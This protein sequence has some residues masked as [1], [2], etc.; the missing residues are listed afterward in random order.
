MLRD[1][2]LSWI[3]LK[4]LMRTYPKITLGH[5]NEKSFHS[6][7]KKQYSK[8]LLYCLNFLFSPEVMVEP[9]TK[10]I[11]IIFTSSKKKE[12]ASEDRKFENHWRN[13]WKNRRKYLQNYVRSPLTKSRDYQPVQLKIKFGTC[14]TDNHIP[15]TCTLGSQTPTGFLHV[16]TFIVFV[17][18]KP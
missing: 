8:I 4:T 14:Y 9:S 5:D 17:R 2:L 6:I 16:P 7:L 3:R 13:R 10:R 18:Q 11:S 15:C 12:Q 1:H